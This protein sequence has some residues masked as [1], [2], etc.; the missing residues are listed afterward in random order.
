MPN[1]TSSIEDLP[2]PL[3]PPP[4]S[5]HE[6]DDFMADLV[7]LVPDD[8]VRDEVCAHLQCMVNRILAGLDAPGHVTLN[9]NGAQLLVT[10]RTGT[11]PALRVV[12][13]VV[14]DYPKR[15]IYF[16]A[17]DLRDPNAGS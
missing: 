12:F 6:N 5:F 7:A 1:A 3:G 16:H 10:E 14:D 8:K 9:R 4:F 2:E 15:H 11:V 13:S 17:V